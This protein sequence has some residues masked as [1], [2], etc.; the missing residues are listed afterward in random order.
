M[1]KQFLIAALALCP[2]TTTAQSISY[3]NEPNIVTHLSLDDFDDKPPLCMLTF[4][5]G[6]THLS[7]YGGP[8]HFALYGRVDNT[9]TSRIVIKVDDNEK[10][11]FGS[12]NGK[13]INA[14]IIDQT[15]LN[16]IEKGKKVVYRIYPAHSF[17]NQQT[18]SVI[19]KNLAKAVAA[20]KQCLRDVATLKDY[21]A[22]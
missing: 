16:Q 12:A 17:Y 2:L 6:T 5:S 8:S 14:Q 3:Y 20:F 19:S 15:L 1:V 11:A 13:I 21:K 4:M 7:F 10:Q 9:S 22:I 18:H